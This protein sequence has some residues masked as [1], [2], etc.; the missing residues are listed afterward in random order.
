MQL[1]YN[2]IINLCHR[3]CRCAVSTGLMRLNAQRRMRV[4][5][6][7]VYYV[8]VYMLTNVVS[9]RIKLLC[10]HWSRTTFYFTRFVRMWRVYKQ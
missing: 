8:Y 1:T 2:I 3:Q 10:M 4:P 6:Y 5:L 7:N 9:S